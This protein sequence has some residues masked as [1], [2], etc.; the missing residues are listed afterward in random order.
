MIESLVNLTVCAVERDRAVIHIAE[1]TH[2]ASA[3]TACGQRVAARLFFTYPPKHWPMGHRW[4]RACL[5]RQ[6][7]G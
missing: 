1:A 3:T 6:H 5:S 4:C 7:Q 2:P